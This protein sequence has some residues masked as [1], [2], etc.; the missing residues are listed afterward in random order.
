M[1]KAERVVAGKAPH[2]FRC[3]SCGK[4]AKPHDVVLWKRIRRD[5]VVFHKDCILREVSRE[6]PATQ[7]ERMKAHLAEF[8]T[9]EGFVNA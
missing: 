4:S 1:M 5:T 7:F 3:V 6:F 2:T 8:G 9:T